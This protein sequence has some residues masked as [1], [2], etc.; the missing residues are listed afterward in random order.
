MDLLSLHAESN[1]VQFDNSGAP[2]PFEVSMS[3]YVAGAAILLAAIGAIVAVLAKMAFKEIR[4]PQ[5]EVQL[6]LPQL[7][8]TKKDEELQHV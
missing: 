1:Q 5:Y 2:P 8:E 4:H 3:I 7:K 6:P